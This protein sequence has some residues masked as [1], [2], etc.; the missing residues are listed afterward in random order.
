MDTLVGIPFLRIISICP[1]IVIGTS[2]RTL[3]FLRDDNILNFLLN[4]FHFF[5]DVLFELYLFISL[6]VLHI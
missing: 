5:K 6:F 1:C 4:L 3:L 2:L